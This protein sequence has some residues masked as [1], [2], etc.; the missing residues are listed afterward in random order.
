MIYHGKLP[1][2]HEAKKAETAGGPQEGGLRPLIEGYTR[3]NLLQ[4]EHD[5]CRDWLAC[6]L[7][8]RDL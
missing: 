1:F 6:L 4:A 5:S 2:P 3:P 8:L 7:G